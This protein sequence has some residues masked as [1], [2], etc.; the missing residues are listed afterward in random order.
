LPSLPTRKLKA[1][2]ELR[3]ERGCGLLSPI[4]RKFRALN[5]EKVER[6][7]KKKGHQSQSPT[8]R[9]L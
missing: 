1:L 7:E 9:K 3:K 5:F 4:T 8:L 2:R 6:K